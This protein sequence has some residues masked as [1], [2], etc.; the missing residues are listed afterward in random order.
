M[1]DEQCP[2]NYKGFETKTNALQLKL[3]EKAAIKSKY[4]KEGGI[5]INDR[6]KKRH[7]VRAFNLCKYIKQRHRTVVIAQEICIPLNYHSV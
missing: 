2:Y 5:K 6:E 4:P 1:Q 3:K 7:E